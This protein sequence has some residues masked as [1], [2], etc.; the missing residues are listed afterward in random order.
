M[1]AAPCYALIVVALTFVA[2]WAS[3]TLMER[4]FLSL[5]DRLAPLSP[6]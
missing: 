4:R 2:G 6:A 5:K 1:L 3:Y